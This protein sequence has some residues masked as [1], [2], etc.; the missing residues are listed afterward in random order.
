VTFLEIE[1]MNGV[2][3]DYVLVDADFSKLKPAFNIYL[4]YL[5]G[6]LTRSKKGT[7]INQSAFEIHQ[8]FKVNNI[9]EKLIYDISLPKE[10]IETYKLKRIKLI[11]GI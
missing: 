11:N 8:N 1:K 3:F 10:K 7:Y 2:E 4:K 5:N 9:F 6:A